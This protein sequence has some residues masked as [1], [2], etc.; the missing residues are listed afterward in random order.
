MNAHNEQHDSASPVVKQNLTTQPAAA[1]EAV[2][3]VGSDHFRSIVD[4]LGPIPPPNTLLYAAPITAAPADLIERCR[5][6]LAWQRTGVLPGDALRAYANA[7]W[8]DEHDPLQ[9]AEKEAAREAFRILARA[10]AASTLAAP[11]IDLTALADRIT[12]HLCE[13][14]YDI[15]GRDELLRHVREAIDASPKGGAHPDDLAVDAFAAAMKAKLADARAK[16]RGGWNGDEPGMHQRLSDLLRAHVEKGDPRDVAN[17]CMF[18]HQRGEGI[19]AP[20]PI[21]RPMDTAPRDGTL[22]RLLVQ[23]EEHLIEDTDE[24][25]WTIGACNDDLVPDDERTGWQIAGWCWEHDHFTEGKGTPVGWLPMLDSPKDGS[26][27]AR[28]D[29]GMIRLSHRD[30]FGEDGYI[31]HTG[32][33][34]RAAI[35]AAM[36]AQAGDAEVQP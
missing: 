3:K 36:Q 2:A 25:A 22:V 28:L 30:E 18:L 32:V 14:E 9:I 1:Q 6:I 10:A 23:F 5:E 33:N 27:T 16:G 24:P 35:D 8:P 29:S 13:H 15:G 7:R 11:G 19:S 17:F 4:W 26:D 20:A 21:P 34:L 12:D 31:L